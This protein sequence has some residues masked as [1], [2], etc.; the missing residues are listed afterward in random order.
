MP[1]HL[2]FAVGEEFMRL[3][4]RKAS[5]DVAASSSARSCVM[6]FSPRCAVRMALTSS[7]GAALLA[8][9]SGGTGLDH[10]NAVLV[11][12]DAC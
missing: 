12:W 11:L 3:F 10:A 8:D 9:V 4:G 5:L 1:E 6:Y 2:E 7:S